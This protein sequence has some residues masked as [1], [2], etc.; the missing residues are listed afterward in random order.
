[1]K[2]RPCGQLYHIHQ[3]NIYTNRIIDR[4]M[5]LITYPAR[6]WINFG[7]REA[8]KPRDKNIHGFYVPMY[9]TPLFNISIT[10]IYNTTIYRHVVII[11]LQICGSRFHRIYFLIS[12]NTASFWQWL[13][14]FIHVCI[15]LD[16]E[17]V[18]FSWLTMTIQQWSGPLLVLLITYCLFRPEILP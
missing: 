11:S 16:M 17:T 2:M 3:G 4:H 8:R 10:M 6:Q 14:I 13:Y 5:I 15:Y 7:R 9:V 12:Y 1:M 18:L